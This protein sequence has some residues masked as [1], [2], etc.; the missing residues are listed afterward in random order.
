MSKLNET[1]NYYDGIANGYSNLYHQ[2]QIKKISYILEYLPKSGRVLD[3]GAG[4]GVLNDFLDRKIIDLFSFDLSCELLKLNP[5]NS[6]RKFCGDLCNLGLFECCS[7]DFICSF[8]VI[9]DLENP[10]FGLD[11]IKRVLKFDGRFIFSFVKFSSKK[12]IILDYID[13]NFKEVFFVEEEKD[14][15]F[16]LDKK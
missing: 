5:N 2:E 1:R 16:V 13:R 15:I 11:E 12:E 9:Q 8:S 4:A 3:A 7:F 14:L 6:D 10:I